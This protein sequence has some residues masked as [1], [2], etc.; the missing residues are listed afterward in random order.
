VS[1][2]RVSVNKGIIN[3]A[4]QAGGDISTEKIAIAMLS[5]TDNDGNDD[6]A[7][8]YNDP[9]S[10]EEA[11]ARPDANKWKEAMKEEW[12]ALLENN[13][14]K[15]FEEELLPGTDMSSL[16]I[17]DLDQ[18][19]PISIPSDANPIDSKWVFRTKLNVDGSTRYK[20]RLVIRGFQQIK[21]IDFDE[22][23]APVSKLTTFRM[24]MAMAAK[25]GWAVDH[26]DVVTAFLNP[27][28]DRDNIYMEL[29]PGIDWIDPRLAGISTVRLKK[30]LYGLKQAPRLWYEEINAFLLSIGFTQ[31]TTDPNLYI[32]SGAALILYVDDILM[33]YDKLNSVGAAIKQQLKERFKMKDLGR[34]KRFLGIEVDE[35]YNISQTSYIKAILRRFRMENAKSATSPMDPN[36]RL[37]NPHCE[38]REANKKLYLSMVGSLMYAALGTRPDLAF[39]VTSLSRYNSRPLA[40]HLTAAKR[41]LRYL[42]STANLKIHYNAPTS[43]NES[44]TTTGFTDSDWAGN[45]TT[46]KSV[47]GCIFSIGSSGPIHWHSKSQSVVALSTLEAEYIA[48]SNATREALWLQRLEADFTLALIKGK[49]HS[50]PVKIG[51]DNQGALKL[52]ETGVIQAKTKHI[53]VKYHHT[54]DEITKGKVAF[55]YVASAENPADILTKALNAHKHNYLLDKLYLKC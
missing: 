50:T 36:V 25:N 35:N 23:Y 42:K 16:R 45:L 9:I 54:R 31:S 38:D 52:L 49:S 46:R 37:D 20:A 13:T 10:I 41:A 48:C 1:K 22:T 2:G 34:V 17:V 30:A 24:M 8:F 21:G 7:N 5:S 55:S 3:D 15:A 12:Q 6:E 18:F 51:C 14:F 28:I 29:P 19:T 44:S 27:K 26:M 32:Q 40:M 53:D 33:A 39:C 11:L 47:G 4:M 43:N